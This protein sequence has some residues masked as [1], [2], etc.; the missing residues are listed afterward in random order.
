[1]PLRV[2][3]RLTKHLRICVHWPSRGPIWAGRH[4]S[5]WSVGVRVPGRSSGWR[6]GTRLTV[7]RTD[8]LRRTGLR[9]RLAAVNGGR[10][11][12]CVLVRIR[13]REACVARRGPRQ[14]LEWLEHQTSP[15]RDA[16]RANPAY[17][18]SARPWQHVTTASHG[19]TVPTPP[20]GAAGGCAKLVCTSSSEDSSTSSHACSSRSPMPTS[21][22]SATSW[23]RRTMAAPR[24]SSRSATR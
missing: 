12:R 3:R 19:G 21:T 15:A 17:G 9:H 1:M 10:C 2:L 14:S 20:P 22:R 18:R 11:G 24:A 6:C 13:V 23:K 5:A 16:S 7:L 4:V 8:P